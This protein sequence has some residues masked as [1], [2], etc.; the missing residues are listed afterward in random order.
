MHIFDNELCL[1]LSLSH[2]QST[3]PWRGRLHSNHCQYVSPSHASHSTITRWTALP[4]SVLPHCRRFH[5][6][7]E[8]S[9]TTLQQISMNR[10][11]LE[12]GHPLLLWIE[13]FLRLEHF[14]SIN[15]NERTFNVKNTELTITLVKRIFGTLS[16]ADPSLLFL[17]P[18]VTAW[19]KQLRY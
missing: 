3:L 16:W 18:N 17:T 5:F 9:S 10:H 2:F 4:S 8:V 6:V 19:L 14:F 1:L 7:A 13:D 12:K 15:S 11:Y